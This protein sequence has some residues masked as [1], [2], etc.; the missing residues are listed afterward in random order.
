MAK[1]KILSFSHLLLDYS[2]IKMVR[3]TIKGK[4]P[5]EH[6]LLLKT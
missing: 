2:I 1:I 3:I 5:W 6:N 4:D